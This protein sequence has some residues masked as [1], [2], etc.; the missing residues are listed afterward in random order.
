MV[1]FGLNYDVKPEYVEEFMKISRAALEA[2]QGVEGHR[3]TRL[4]QDVDRPNSYLI[5]SDWETKEAFAAFL[6]SDA[7]KQVQGAGREMLENPPRHNVYTK[8]PMG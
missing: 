7:F 8:G 5:Y 6:R 3:E 1:T 4:Y 2:M